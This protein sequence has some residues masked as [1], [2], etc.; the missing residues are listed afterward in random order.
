[1]NNIYKF[2]FCFFVLSFTYGLLSHFFLDNQKSARVVFEDKAILV[3]KNELAQKYVENLFNKIGNN[4]EKKEELEIGINYLKSKLQTHENNILAEKKI[5]NNLMTEA[6]IKDST[7]NVTT[8][9]VDIKKTSNKIVDY[10]IITKNQI[11][12]KIKNTKKPKE[13]VLSA[14]MDN[15]VLVSKV[16]SKISPSK[17][18]ELTKSLNLS[19]KGS[20]AK[21]VY[22]K[23]SNLNQ[24]SKFYEANSTKNDYKPDNQKFAEKYQ[25]I[26]V[27]RLERVKKLNEDF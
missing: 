4:E 18:K 2:A 11:E 21:I 10:E 8:K 9:D 6:K 22:D 1:M 12:E 19:V 3:K 24:Y 5:E 17:T 16:Q 20:N 7:K 23:N 25:Q 27:A 15:K 14:N 26:Q 13:T